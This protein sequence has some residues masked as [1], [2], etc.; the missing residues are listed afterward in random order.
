[1]CKPGSP[2]LVLKRRSPYFLLYGFLM[3]LN[4]EGHIS[5]YKKQYNLIQ[6]FLFHK[7]DLQWGME[8]IR[9]VLPDSYNIGALFIVLDK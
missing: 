3:S 5:K 2:R 7:R 1:M 8:E 6:Y 9:Q 4:N